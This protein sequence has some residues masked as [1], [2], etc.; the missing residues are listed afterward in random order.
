MFIIFKNNKKFIKLKYE[1]FINFSRLSK[2]E[3]TISDLNWKIKFYVVQTFYSF[4]FDHQNQRIYLK[5][6]R[7]TDKK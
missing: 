3:C 7:Q 1:S 2:F 5:N 6:P 4:H